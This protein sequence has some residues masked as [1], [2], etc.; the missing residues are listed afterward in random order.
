MDDL[1]AGVK[2][3]HGARG[4]AGSRKSRSPKARSFSTFFVK[5]TWFSS[6]RSAVMLS[7]MDVVE[8]VFE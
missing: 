4:W 8:L 6:M 7:W 2:Y 3:E 1:I 5:S